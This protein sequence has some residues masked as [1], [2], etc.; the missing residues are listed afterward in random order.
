MSATLGSRFTIETAWGLDKGFRG[1]IAMATSND[2]TVLS[3][4]GISAVRSHQL[5][6]SQT[7]GMSRLH[8]SLSATFNGDWLVIGVPSGTDAFHL[9]RFLSAPLLT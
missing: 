9:S 3:P 7:A 8:D 2:E 4:S 5:R 1:P 6:I